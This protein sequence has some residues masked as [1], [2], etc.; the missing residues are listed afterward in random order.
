MNETER[1]RPWAAAQGLLFWGKINILQVAKS[2]AYCAPKRTDTSFDT[3]GS[4]I[5][6]P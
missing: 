6:T 1:E 5:V 3:P 2:A 4:C